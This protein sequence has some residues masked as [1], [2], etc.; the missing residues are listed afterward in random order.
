MPEPEQQPPRQGA[1]P[2]ETLQPCVTRPVRFDRRDIQGAMTFTDQKDSLLDEVRRLES[3]LI[4]FALAADE[5]T[6][7]TRSSERHL[8][9]NAAVRDKL[10]TFVR[11]FDSLAFNVTEGSPLN[12]L[13]AP[14]AA[15]VDSKAMRF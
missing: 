10:P 6:P 13:P 5:T 2:G 4:A 8:V 15:S 14:R 3:L 11:Q 1:P 9:H 7:N 12:D